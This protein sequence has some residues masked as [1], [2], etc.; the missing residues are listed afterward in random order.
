[1]C[2]PKNPNPWNKRHSD[3]VV[4]RAVELREFGYG[5]TRIS[6]LLYRETGQTI[7]PNTI[8]DWIRN[9]TRIAA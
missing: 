4:Q 6:K 3:E 9:R 1:M 5:E 2:R 8:R 7:S